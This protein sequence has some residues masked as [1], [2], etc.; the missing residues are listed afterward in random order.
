MYTSPTPEFV[1]GTPTTAV[2]PSTAMFSPTGSL[3]REAVSAAA[4]VNEPLNRLSTCATPSS[5]PS[6]RS[7][8]GAPTTAMLPLA[9]VLAPNSWIDPSEN[10][11]LSTDPST[12]GGPVLP[13]PSPRPVPYSS[14][15]NSGSAS[16]IR[17]VLPA[18]VFSGSIPASSR[19]SDSERTAHRGGSVGR[20]R[21]PSVSS[22]PRPGV[23]TVR[24]P[25]RHSRSRVSP[26]RRP[27]DPRGVRR[28]EDFRSYP[29][30]RRPT[31]HRRG[32]TRQL[33][34]SWRAR[35]GIDIRDRALRGGGVET[36]QAIVDQ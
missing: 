29:R 34:P 4:C 25:R 31:D 8:L 13:P 28:V 1:P 23:P 35:G 18:S 9:E 3:G 19:K 5:L 30:A 20:W 21:L 17:S 16:L 27:V 2:L 22:H 7:V 10:S 33:C 14:W 36:Y 6:P 12:V 15:L 26:A 24:R 11:V 32:R